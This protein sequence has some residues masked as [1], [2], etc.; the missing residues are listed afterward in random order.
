MFARIGKF[1]T[2][3]SLLS[4]IW[5]AEAARLQLA[6]VQCRRRCAVFEKEIDASWTPPNASRRAPRSPRR[7]A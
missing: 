4:F 5:E 2:T 7:C 6:E 3:V 1:P